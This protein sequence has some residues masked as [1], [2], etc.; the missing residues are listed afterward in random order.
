MGGPLPLNA[1]IYDRYRRHGHPQPNHG[2]HSGER[3]C[4]RTGA[5]QGVVCVRAA[6][7]AASRHLAGHTRSGVAW[8]SRGCLCAWVSMA[9]ARLQ[10]MPDASQQRRVLA[11]EDCQE[12]GARPQSDRGTSRVRLAGVGRVGMRAQVA[13]AGCNGQQGGTVAA[14][15]TRG[16][17]GHPAIGWQG[18]KYIIPFFFPHRESKPPPH[19][20]WL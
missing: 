2:A 7:P 5:A 15:W 13:H 12:S 1:R 10:Q 9:L 4:A 3:H 18:V 11:G 20:S 14:L 8:A 6:L 16:I 17:P 19:A